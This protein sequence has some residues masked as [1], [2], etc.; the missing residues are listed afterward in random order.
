[1]PWFVDRG[2]TVAHPM[3]GYWRDLGQP[4]HYLAAHQDLL[5]DDQGLFDDPNWPIMTRQPQRVPARVVA[6]GR[7]EESL[8]S[9]GVRVFGEVV[10]SVLG[11][12]VVVEKGAVV[13]NSV[14]FMDSVIGAGAQVDWAI[15]DERCRVEPGA[16]V[17]SP[18]ADGTSDSDAVTIIGR[19]SVVSQDLDEGARLEPGTT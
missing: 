1:V 2:R 16:V 6:G 18:D 11:P 4:H 8:L 17:G 13:R 10:R 12:G 14:V 5:T 3:P 7:V 19:E 15:V 9:P